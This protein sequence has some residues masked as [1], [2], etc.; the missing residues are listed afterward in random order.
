MLLKINI[1]LL[2]SL[3]I[4]CNGGSNANAVSPTKTE[5]LY[6]ASDEILNDIPNDLSKTEYLTWTKEEASKYLEINQ[7]INEFKISMQYHPAE[8][9]ALKELGANEANKTKYQQLIKEKS[10][11][12]YFTLKIEIP[13]SQQEILK[14]KTSDNSDYESRLNYMA[15]ELQ[16]DIVIVKGKDSIEPVLYHFERLFDT[17]P[18][19]QFLLAFP[20]DSSNADRHLIY[21]DHVFSLGTFKFYFRKELFVKLPKINDI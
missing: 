21:D 6:S 18:Y 3:L 1:L 11:V 12:D 17:A 8:Q 9:L 7:M 4:S 14:Y 19:C 10:T 16:K 15:Y 20:K 13:G 2:L 5:T